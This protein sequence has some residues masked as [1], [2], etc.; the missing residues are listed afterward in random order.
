MAVTIDIN[1]ATIDFCLNPVA[2]KITGS[3]SPIKL[4]ARLFIEEVYG[5]GTYTQIPDVYLDP[6]SNYSAVFYFGELLKEYFDDVKTDIFNLS[7]ITKDEHSLKKY[8]VEFYEWDGTNLG[9][10]KLSETKYILSGQLPFQEWPS[11][12]F[13]ATLPITLDYLNNAGNK[14]NTWT[15]A[16]QYLFWINHVAGSN[17]IELRATIHYTDKTSETQTIN[18]IENAEQYDVLIIPSGYAQLSLAT[19]NSEKT[20]YRYDIGLFKEDNTQVGKSISYYLQNKPWWA[21]Q[22]LFRNNYGVLEALKVEGKEASELKTSFTTSEKTLQYNYNKTDFQFVQRKTS[23]TK[24][25]KINIGP[26]TKSEAEHLDELLN[27]KLFKIGKSELIPCNILSKS[28]T[29][30]DQNEDLQTVSLKYQYAFQI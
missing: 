12:N 26:L 1:P 18:T 2:Y 15:S 10:V 23:R 11:H 17:T 9:A 6:D 30:Y 4:V 27:D 28:I 3:A 7:V 29:P 13:A 25:F 14:I 22:F 21:N 20:I 16:K 24:E 5:S 8:Y 19:Y